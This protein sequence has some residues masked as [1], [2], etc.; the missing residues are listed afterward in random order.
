MWGNNNPEIIKLLLDKK[1]NIDQ[2]DKVSYLFSLFNDE[3]RVNE[4]VVYIVIIF[5]NTERLDD[6]NV[7]M[8]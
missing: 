7:G 2:V 5:L 1:A 8:L 3:T 6:S 4:I